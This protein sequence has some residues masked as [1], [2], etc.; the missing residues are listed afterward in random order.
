M[1]YLK[2]TAVWRHRELL[3]EA[4]ER[5]LTRRLK[6]G[7]PARKR[8]FAGAMR[9]R[10]ALLVS[11]MGLAILMAAGAA[12]ALLLA[13]VHG[14]NVAGKQCL[15]TDASD[16]MKG[17]EENDDIRGMGD[18]D[19]VR[20]LG[21]IDALEGDDENLSLSGQGDDRVFGG[22]GG[23]DLVG[24]N[25]S[26]LLVGGRGA[27]SIDAIEASSNGGTDTARGG[28]GNDD[29]TANDG[30]KDAIDCGDGRDAVEFD[31]RLDKVRNCEVKTAL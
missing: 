2:E 26:D 8:S 9:L 10:A 25:G 18:N 21:G 14:S 6:A 31:A 1:Y 29:V 23:D 12:Y 3:R 19:V 15:G 16:T 7:R 13:F 30:Q 27:D 28:R 11:T 22:G 5:R 24:L 4:E 17:T 20:G